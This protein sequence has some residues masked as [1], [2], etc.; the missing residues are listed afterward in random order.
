M[1]T[2]GAFSALTSYAGLWRIEVVTFKVAREYLLGQEGTILN[3][4]FEQESS[5]RFLRN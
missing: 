5:K 4:V 1:R 2:V 3:R